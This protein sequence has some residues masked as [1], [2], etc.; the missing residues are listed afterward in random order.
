MKINWGT[1][2]V[3]AFAGFIVFIMYFVIRVS[4]D[5]RADHELVTESYYKKELGYQK[6][7]D[8][9][10]SVLENNARLQF[11]KT[12]EGLRI[13]FPQ[14][15]DASE[16]AGTLGLYRPSNRKLDVEIPL[17]LEGAELLIPA[18]QLLEGRWDI[19]IAWEYR[20]KQFLQKEKLIY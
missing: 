11:T 3:L 2:I 8:A 10:R 16:I 6:E 14:G 20:G 15:Y 4:T 18:S 9:Q 5:D 12:A 19:T 17:E 1:A 7:I 13:E